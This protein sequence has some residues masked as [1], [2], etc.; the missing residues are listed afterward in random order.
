MVGDKVVVFVNDEYGYEEFFPANKHWILPFLVN[1]SLFI[2]LRNLCCYWHF[3]FEEFEKKSQVL[4]M[5][6]MKGIEGLIFLRDWFLKF[7]VN[8]F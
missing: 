3:D 1:D 6:V 8:C 5:Y 7:E 2:F 4:L